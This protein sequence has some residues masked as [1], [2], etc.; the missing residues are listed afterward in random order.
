MEANMSKKF[1]NTETQ[2]EEDKLEALPILPEALQ[3]IVPK[4]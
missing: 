4:V 3:I 1:V 2:T